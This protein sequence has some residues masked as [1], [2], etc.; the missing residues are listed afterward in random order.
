GGIIRSV[1][2]IITEKPSIKYI[3]ITP[4]FNLH[5][6]TGQVNVSVK[7]WEEDVNKV[8]FKYIFKEKKSEKVISSKTIELSVSNNEFLKAFDLGKIKP[9]HFDSPHLYI[10]ETYVVTEEGISDNEISTFGFKKLEL[11]GQ[12]LYLNGEKVR[13]PGIEYMANSN[14]NFGAA[15]PRNVMDSVVYAMKDLN[16][17]IT[18]FHWQQD[19]YLLDLMD[20]YGI[21]VQKEIPWWQQ[22]GNLTTELMNTAQKQ[23]SDMI[24]AHYNHP[25]I[26]SWG[27][28]NEVNGGTKK[29]TILTLKDYVKNLDSSRMVTVVSNKMWK[30]KGNDESLLCDL[31]TWNEYIG[32]W[33]AENR[34]QLPEMFEIVKNTI[35]D[36][37]LLITENGI[38]EPAFTGGD[39]RR[40]DEMIYHIGE[41]SKRPY[42]I[43]YIY[44]SL[45][46]YRT[47]MGEE[48]FGK[49]KIRRH[50][51]MD[52]NLKPK[53][54][55]SVL[56]QI[57]S[58]IEITKIERIENEHAMLEFRVKNTIPQYTL[59]SYKI[60]YYTIGNELLEIPLPDLKPGET[61]S[62]QLDNINSRFSFKILRPN[63]FCVVQY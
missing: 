58:P 12:T 24:E 41:W 4:N 38:S 17:C 47:H 32:T 54:S 15:E 45:N 56:K 30:R 37:P 62:T 2:L 51:I 49:Y 61:F 31:P 22:P 19:D 21:L 43:G 55:Y 25:S 39:A 20:E 11:K 42:I 1:S 10:L 23:L 9:W 57:A 63:G 3:H 52:L 40:I 34:N 36:R 18:R 14:P 46:D 27:L 6:S 53:P 44:F 35:G 8:K 29:E 16:V 60:Q 7:V 28:S 5:D 13:L 50:G 26:F 48:G 59:R 33:H